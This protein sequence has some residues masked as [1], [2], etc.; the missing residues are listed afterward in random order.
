MFATALDSLSRMKLPADVEVVFCLVENADDLNVRAEIETFEKSVPD[1][2]VI[3][4]NEPRLG[5]PFARN[6]ALDLALKAGCD[7]LAFIDDDETV[8][9]D[10]LCK[11]LDTLRERELDLV[12]GPVRTLAPKDDLP[13]L[14]R[15][16]LQGL[17]ARARRIETAAR[18][19]TANKLDHTVS[20]VTNNWL[21]RLDFLRRTGIRFDEGL[22]LSGG[23]DIAIFREIRQAGGKTGWAPDAVVYEEIPAGRLSFAYQYARGRDQ[24]LATY[25][26][27]RAQSGRA[28]VLS[29]SGFILTKT[30]VGALRV[31]FSPFFG[32]TTLVLG[33]RAFGA[34]AGRLRG[35]TGARSTHYDRVA[36]H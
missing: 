11:L 8:D 1:C 20:I 35:L 28:R 13:W 25:N 17:I 12:G 4:G 29:S 36:G 31:L 5:I 16:I 18:L 15:S 3:F 22:G 33:L 6:A 32:G 21:A 2:K 30:L 9:G 14:Q 24:Q 27:K 10:W 34:A 7:W 19:R 26:I 23:S